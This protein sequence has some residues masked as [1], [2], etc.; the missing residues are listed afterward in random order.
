MSR[1]PL[2]VI[3]RFFLGI[4]TSC[5]M[6]CSYCFVR[7][8]DESMSY[9]EAKK[10]LLAF[11]RNFD[12]NCLLYF[13]GGEPFLCFGLMRRLVPFFYSAAHRAGKSPRVLVVTNG[14]ILTIPMLRFLKHSRIKIMVSFSGAP[15]IHDGWRRFKNNG[16]GT[17][18][19][20]RKNVDALLE[21]LPGEDVWVSHTFVP[22]M[23]S[24]FEEDVARYEKMGFTNFHFEPV[25]FVAGVRWSGAAVARYEK[26]LTRTYR[27]IKDRISRGNALFSSNLIRHLEILLGISPPLGGAYDL[28]NN[29]RIWPKYR[30]GFSHFLIN[31]DRA[32]PQGAPPG[33]R[34]QAV[35]SGSRN[36]QERQG[37]CFDFSQPGQAGSLRHGSG[38]RIWAC[39]NTVCRSAAADLIRSSYEDPR[40]GQYIREA[41]VKAI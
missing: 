33:G 37:A 4:T 6:R 40:F 28:Y 17:F 8:R 30:A 10:C 16:R 25:Q 11:M 13:Y 41:L 15:K 27:R 14:T 9:E 22:A 21:H 34:A 7:R 32:A 38:R 24:T 36:R 23:L 39:Y 31:E 2:F 35:F 29:I 5:N 1:P 20:I 3:R 19:R 12:R 18:S 26:A